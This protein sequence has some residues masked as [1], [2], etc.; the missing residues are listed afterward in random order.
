MFGMGNNDD[1][2]RFW[3]LVVF[4]VYATDKE[5]EEIIPLILGIGLVV[6]IIIFLFW[7]FS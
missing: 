2:Q 4:K 6:G 5:M 1:D 7:L 3:N